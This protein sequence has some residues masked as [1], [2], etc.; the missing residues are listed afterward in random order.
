MFDYERE[1]SRRPQWIGDVDASFGLRDMEP[2]DVA[3]LWVSVGEFGAE[4]GEAMACESCW[5]RYLCPESRL[6]PMFAAASEPKERRCNLLR[7][8]FEAGVRLHHRL[9]QMDPLA[10]HTFLELALRASSDPS[11]GAIGVRNFA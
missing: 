9:T 1:P 3:K 11:R 10:T 2:P 4:P 5:A 8:Q 7:A 6:L